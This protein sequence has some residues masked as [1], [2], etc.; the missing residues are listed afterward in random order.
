MDDLQ[1]ETEV[2]AEQPIQKRKQKP[3]SR[4]LR[5]WRKTQRGERALAKIRGF[6]AGDKLGARILTYLRKVDPFVFEEMLLSALEEG[7]F[8][9]R[10]NRQYTG[11][12][13]VDGR[14]EA[15]DG[16]H[17]LVQAKR[18]RSHVRPRDVEE[19]AGRVGSSDAS[20]GLFVH[21]GRTGPESHRRKSNHVQIVSG[22]QLVEMLLNP[23][24]FKLQERPSVFEDAATVTAMAESVTNLSLD[25]LG[26]RM[27]QT[28]ARMEYALKAAG[29][30][31]SDGPA[32]ADWDRFGRDCDQY[33][34]ET[35]CT[36]SRAAINYIM[37][38]PPKRQDIVNGLLHWREV[39]A[40]K[41]TLGEALLVYVR[42][43]R[44]NL[45][46]GGKFNGHWF[47]PERSETLLRHSLV[48]LEACRNANPAVREAYEG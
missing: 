34:Q 30:H 4:P 12:G 46:H 37:E 24:E 21:T 5:H 23:A 1:N 9:I 43:V 17:V 13:G 39:D 38:Q 25:E 47:A 10:R 3:I 27:F 41:Q 18:Y 20:I 48:V 33:F 26:L 29:Y 32:K 45:F 22:S 35:A 8:R 16:T 44:N 36:E 42:R 6:E 19:F 11:D 31:G 7:G 2:A 15:K 40:H 28:F 14:L